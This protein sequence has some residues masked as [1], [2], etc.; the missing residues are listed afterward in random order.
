M[1]GAIIRVLSR[2]GPVTQ[3]DLCD[4]VYREITDNQH[5]FDLI[6][7]ELIFENMIK[8]KNGLVQL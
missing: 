7:H 5:D 1:R 4:F 3:D 8:I 6:L 2:T